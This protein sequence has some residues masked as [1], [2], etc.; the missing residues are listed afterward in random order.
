MSRA[1]DVANLGSDTTNLEDISSAYDAGALSN[2]N[3]IIN[4]AMV[5]DQR[6]AGAEVS[7]APSGYTVDRFATFKSGAGTFKVQQSTDAP[8]SFSNSLLLTVTGAS[9]PSTGDYY[10]LQHPIEGYNIADF[11]WGTA[12]AKSVVLSFKVKSS[13]TGLFSG[14]I[15]NDSASHSYVFTFNIASADTWEDK[16]IVVE[17][18]TVGTWLSANNR[19]L[20][21][22][23]SL[24][25]G[26]TFAT[27]TTGSWVSGNFHGST[28]EV[29]WI[30]T[31]GATFQITGVQLEAGTVAT[32]FEHRSFGQELALCQRYCQVFRSIGGEFDYFASGAFYNSTQ[33][34]FYKPLLVPMRT[35][36]TFSSTAFGSFHVDAVSY[37]S[38]SSLSLEAAEKE[39]VRLGF[40]ASSA[41]SNAAGYGAFLASSTS[42][43]EILSFFA[44]L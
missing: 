14:S 42:S 27:G 34:R 11:S 13:L 18:P 43:T 39:S 24:G 16:E 10:I 21:I 22:V 25:Q 28:G 4:G 44:E 41:G 9:T 32:P 12:S 2:R 8:A 29:D 38:L 19:G 30:A 3:K 1:R 23:V 7:P 37:V 35:A 36:P 33:G 20:M 5:I 40:T 26:S 17:G 31:S 15:R 6:N